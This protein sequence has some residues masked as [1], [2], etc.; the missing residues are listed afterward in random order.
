MKICQRDGRGRSWFDEDA[1]FKI[2]GKPP[3][4]F[5]SGAQKYT[6]QWHTLGQRGETFRGACQGLRRFSDGGNLWIKF[7]A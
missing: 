1:R 6:P 5:L 4:D 7:S 2:T 3:E